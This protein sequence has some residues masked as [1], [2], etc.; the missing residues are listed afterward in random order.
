MTS[1]H[2]IS[3]YKALIQSVQEMHELWFPNPPFT[4]ETYSIRELMELSS[5]LRSNTYSKLA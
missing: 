4:V 2:H 5:T 3:T 1:R